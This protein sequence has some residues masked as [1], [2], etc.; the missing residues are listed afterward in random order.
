MNSLTRIRSYMKTY[1]SVTCVQQSQSLI[2]FQQFRFLGRTCPRAGCFAPLGHNLKVRFAGSTLP[3]SLVQTEHQ[4]VIR[5][6]CRCVH[7]G[8]G[9]VAPPQGKI[10]RSYFVPFLQTSRRSLSSANI[11]TKINW[12]DDVIK[13]ARRLRKASKRTWESSK[14]VEYIF[15]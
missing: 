5:G 4:G 7:G 8:N 12:N 13:S 2:S 15:Q 10:V 1:E 3:D 9:P 6:L 14:I 11:P